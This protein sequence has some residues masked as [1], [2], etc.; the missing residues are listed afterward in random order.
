MK[1]I[2]DQFDSLKGAK[3]VGLNNYVS[4]TSGEVSN[5][6]LNTNINTMNAKEKD[7]ATLKAFKG[8]AK[9]AQK[10]GIDESIVC[11]GLT[12]LIASAEKNLTDEK[13]VSSQAQIDA[14]INLG[15][16]LRIHKEDFSLHVSGFVQ[17]KKVLVEGVYKTVNSRPKTL[18]KNAIQ[19]ECKLR[20]LK[21]RTYKFKNLDALNV[22]GNHIV[23]K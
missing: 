13:T 22:Q 9:I 19:K 20:M 23:I 2:F 6:V 8:T 3:F 16:G 12:E 11:E 18:A 7:L 1:A 15:N 4:S 21:Y 17:S 10:L 5:V 14:Y